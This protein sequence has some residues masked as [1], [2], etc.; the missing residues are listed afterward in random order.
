MRFLLVYSPE[1]ENL[2]YVQFLVDIDEDKIDDVLLA[3]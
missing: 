3:A 2:A 1:P